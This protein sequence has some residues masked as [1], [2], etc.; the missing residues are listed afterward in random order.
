MFELN[1]SIETLYLATGVAVAVA[2]LM[3]LRMLTSE[4]PDLLKS[5]IFLKFDTLVKAAYVSSAAAVFYVIANIAHYLNVD[6]F[7]HNIGEIVFNIGIIISITIIYR[8]LKKKS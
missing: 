2:I 3:S 8:S 4:G 1:G 7:I 6:V 5:R